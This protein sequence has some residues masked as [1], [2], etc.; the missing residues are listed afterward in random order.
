MI[1][2]KLNN[3]KIRAER[4]VTFM[5]ACQTKRSKHEKRGHWVNENKR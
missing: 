2:F 5:C 3:E 4:N 1:E